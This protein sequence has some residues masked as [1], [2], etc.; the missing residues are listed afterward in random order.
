[1]DGDLIKKSEQM[2]EL[3]RTEEETRRFLKLNS[4]S[5]RLLGKQLRQ[6]ASSLGEK[7]KY[8]NQITKLK[9]L[10]V[11]AKRRLQQHHHAV[12]A[13]LEA[14][15]K[16]NIRSQRVQWIDIKSAFSSRIRTAGVINLQHKF[17]ETFL[18]DAMVLVKRRLQNLLKKNL[19]IKVNFELSCKYELLRTD[20]VEDKYFNTANVMLTPT[21]DL[22]EVL[23]ECC[24][25]L[26]TKVSPLYKH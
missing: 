25:S 7:N 3:L 10:Q 8:E 16:R 18:P 23:T 22:D 6:L 12:G 4:A 5:L 19:N 17:V 14:G 11:K 15:K 20:E 9:G 1:M 26:R 13:G 24:N 2:L 21:T